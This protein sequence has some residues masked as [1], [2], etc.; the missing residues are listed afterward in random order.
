MRFESEAIRQLLSGQ[1]LGG[2]GL[3]RNANES[4]QT[5]VQT[6]THAE[7]GLTDETEAS[8]GGAYREPTTVGSTKRACLPSSSSSHTYEISMRH[9][10]PRSRLPSCVVSFLFQLQQRGGYKPKC[11]FACRI[12]TASE[13]VSRSR[14]Y[15]ERRHKQK[16]SKHSRNAAK[17]R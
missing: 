9:A 15:S 3:K 1:A 6:K 14:V 8:E 10:C 12:R 17:S 11:A 16:P 4:S 7:S 13:V 2:I 5:R